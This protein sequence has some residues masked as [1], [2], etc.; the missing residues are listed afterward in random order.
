MLTPEAQTLLLT[1]FLQLR[2]LSPVA[3][4]TASAETRRSAGTGVVSTRAS[5][6]ILVLRTQS[7]Q[8][9]HIPSAATVRLVT[10]ETAFQIV[11]PVSEQN[12]LKTTEQLFDKIT[13]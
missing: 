10:Q 9:E 1:P 13:I 12:G 6:Q 5:L 7:A 11:I 3:H 4:R 2:P 8:C